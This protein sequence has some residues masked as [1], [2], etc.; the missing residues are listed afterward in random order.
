MVSVIN[1]VDALRFCISRRQ[2]R[3]IGD[4][5]NRVEFDIFGGG[6]AVIFNGIGQ[7]VEQETV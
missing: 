4:V 2:F 7:Y 1:V 3:G 6:T 5:V